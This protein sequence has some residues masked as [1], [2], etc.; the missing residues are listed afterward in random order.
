MHSSRRPA[1][2]IGPRSCSP[3]ITRTPESTNC[4][5]P[6]FPVTS[7]SS[8]GARKRL[9]LRTYQGSIISR[10]A[11]IHAT[12]EPEAEHIREL[13]FFHKPIFVIP[14]AVSEP[15]ATTTRRPAT[16]PGERST[17]LF[18]SRVHEKKG[19]DNLLS[20]WH[21]LRPAHWTLKIVGSGEPSYVARLK[22]LCAE[23]PIANV[24]FHPH[25]DG[26]ARERM[27][28]GASA[29][30]LPTFSEN[31]GNA[32]AEA[33]LRGLPVITTTGTPWSVIAEKKLG[34]YVEPTLE[35][36]TG[37]LKA[38]FESDAAHL[39]DMGERAG[40]YARAHLS[41]D[42]VRSRLLAMYTA[43]LKP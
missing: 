7:T 18:L 12:S 17:L 3:P 25:V 33:M 36:L 1:S 34:W 10:A 20:A 5:R 9:A 16:L 6:S 21:A 28:E 27:F 41:V 19:L 23:K 24:E 14:N 43:T 40:H 8:T 29:F 15:G 37:A 30:V 35:Q 38:L 22:R 39:S 4:S 42:A 2:V 31:F 32:I 11:A 13:G 26:D